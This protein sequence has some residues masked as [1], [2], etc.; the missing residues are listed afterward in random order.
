[1]MMPLNIFEQNDSFFDTAEKVKQEVS[2]ESD[3]RL[4]YNWV[5]K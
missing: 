3:F 4:S 2:E 1:M 5:R